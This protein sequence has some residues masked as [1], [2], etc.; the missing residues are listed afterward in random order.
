MK[1]A[2]CIL[3]RSINNQNEIIKSSIIL[4]EEGFSNHVD[5]LID[6]NEYI[7]VFGE[8]IVPYMRG[9]NS[10]IGFKT[11]DFLEA[12]NLT[13]AFATSDNCLI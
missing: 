10:P 13:K 6:S 4:N 11:K 12:R 1:L 9:W 3:G 5:W 7:E 8:N 2:F